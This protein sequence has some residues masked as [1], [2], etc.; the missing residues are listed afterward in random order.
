MENDSSMGPERTP[1][2][3]PG[4]RRR[5]Y[6]TPRAKVDDIVDYIRVKHNWGVSDFIHAFATAEPEELYD[7]S[8]ANRA[9]DLA[10]IVFGKKDKNNEMEGV[11]RLEEHLSGSAISSG[12]LPLLR[13]E[14]AALQEAEEGFFGKWD[15]ADQS[16][17][18]DINFASVV[19]KMEQT[20]PLLYG[21]LKGLM[22]PID[23]RE[24]KAFS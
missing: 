11:I 6:M 20:S 15:I 4:A 10:A 16:N 5:P 21:L 3:L 2:R 23:K 18:D 14:M 19:A 13:N 7:R 8:T 24:L 22:E 17:V 9:K 1:A 12:L